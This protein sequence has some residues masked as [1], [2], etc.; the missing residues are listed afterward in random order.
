MKEIDVNSQVLPPQGVGK[1]VL[2]YHKIRLG[3]PGYEAVSTPEGTITVFGPS[4]SVNIVSSG[5]IVV[6]DGRY[7]FQ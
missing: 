6:G 4:K 3:T 1:E 7:D 2:N 5:G